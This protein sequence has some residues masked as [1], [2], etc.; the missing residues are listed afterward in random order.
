MYDITNIIA[1]NLITSHSHDHFFVI[2][3]KNFV[4]G[5]RPLN[6]CNTWNFCEA[7]IIKLSSLLHDNLQDLLCRRNESIWHFLL[8]QF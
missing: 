4:D 3:H 2:S 7:E 6:M 8:L 5:I 1:L